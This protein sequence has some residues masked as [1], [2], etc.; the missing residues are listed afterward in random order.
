MAF[1][2][3]EDHRMELVPGTGMLVNSVVNARPW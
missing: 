1:G 3:L 2:I